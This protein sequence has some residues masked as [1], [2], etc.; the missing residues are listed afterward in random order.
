MQVLFTKAEICENEKL[1]ERE[2]SIRFENIGELKLITNFHQLVLNVNF[3]NIE[4]IMNEVN[5]TIH[6]IKLEKY[7]D[8]F[9]K[10]LTVAHENLKKLQGIFY[11]IFEDTPSQRVKKRS[12][13]TA[14]I[15]KISLMTNIENENLSENLFIIRQGM[16]A[17]YN[18]S[19]D[20]LKEFQN[21]TKNQNYTNAELTKEVIFNEISNKI[22]TV[23]TKIRSILTMQHLERLSSTFEITEGLNKTL[24]EIK[25]NLTNDENMPYSTINE[26]VYNLK[27]GHTT[28]GKVLNLFVNVPL[29]EKNNRKLYKIHELPTN[30]NN[31]LIITNVKWRYIAIGKEN[32]MM[33]N[34]I[35][36]CLKGVKSNTFMCSEQSPLINANDKSDCLMY[37][38]NLK[39][40][41]HD[42]CKTAGVKL[43]KLTFIRLGN[44]EY[45]YYSPKDENPSLTIRCDDKIKNIRL[46]HGTGILRFQ[47]G[48]TLNT[49]KLRIISTRTFSKSQISSINVRY[50]GPSLDQLKSYLQFPEFIDDE[51]HLRKI[52]NPV[53]ILSSPQA[54]MANIELIAIALVGIV[55]FILFLILFLKLKK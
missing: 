9:N 19:I 2:G 28:K 18:R 51:D 11:D 53:H 3:T 37:A 25:L 40:I 7:D 5:T 8:K 31:N 1:N 41:N 44:A 55:G 43:T 27:V 42:V 49:S 35:D 26:Y 48:C 30:E 4:T 17:S 36:H 22:Y 13:D 33:L 6:H 46:E 45:F 21:V 15:S 32:V 14:L 39:E 52:S 54:A 29:I 10:K 34:S 16:N 20:L 50:T 24:E 12:L 38:F 23:K 47:Q